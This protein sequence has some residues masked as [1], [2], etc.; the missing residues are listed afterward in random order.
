MLTSKKGVSALRIYRDMG[1]GSCK[2]AWEMCHKIH[3]ALL[4]DIEKLG[5][6]VEADKWSPR[7]F[8]MTLGIISE[9]PRSEFIPRR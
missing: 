4:E 3:V 9:V 8:P 7:S 1:F 2:T 6:I 5:G